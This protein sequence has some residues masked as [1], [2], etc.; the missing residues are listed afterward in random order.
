V[1]IGDDTCDPARESPCVIDQLVFV[2]H[3]SRS[4]GRVIV[5]VSAGKD[6]PSFDGATVCEASKQSRFS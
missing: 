4:T 1:A 3:V 2:S 6:H 5:D